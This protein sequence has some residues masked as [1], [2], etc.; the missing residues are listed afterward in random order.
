VFSVRNATSVL[1]FVEAFN[2]RNESF[3]VSKETPIPSKND[4][5]DPTRY[6]GDITVTAGIQ[7]GVTYRVRFRAVNVTDNLTSVGDDTNV[8][9]GKPAKLFEVVELQITPTTLKF[10]PINASSKVRTDVSIFPQSAAPAYAA[11]V[12]K[13]RQPQVRQRCLCVKLTRLQCWHCW[14]LQ[15]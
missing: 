11:P 7:E 8:F 10:V 13:R 1:A 15:W 14:R 2:A 12:T 5:G 4:P 9:T 6:E 3:Q